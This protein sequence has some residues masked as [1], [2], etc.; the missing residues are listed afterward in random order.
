MNSGFVVDQLALATHIHRVRKLEGLI[1]LH[2]VTAWWSNT[3]LVLQMIALTLLW[4]EFGL[5][6]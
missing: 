5:I 1:K 6:L 3:M 4:K 2:P